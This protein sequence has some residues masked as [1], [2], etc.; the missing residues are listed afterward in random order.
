MTPPDC[1]LNGFVPY[2]M[3]FGLDTA[4]DCTAMHVDIQGLA[5]GPNQEILVAAT[6]TAN[7]GS[8]YPASCFNGRRSVLAMIDMNGITKWVRTA[9]K[10]GT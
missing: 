5:W 3:I 4:N 10:D 8:S 9:M 7:S 1:G 6:I 2:P